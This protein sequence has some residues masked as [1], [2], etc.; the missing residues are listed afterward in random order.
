MI[1]N[2]FALQDRASTATLHVAIDPNRFVPDLQS[3]LGPMEDSNTTLNLD[4]TVSLEGVDMNAAT[5]AVMDY[6][7][8]VLGSGFVPPVPVSSA[9]S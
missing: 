7:W 5:L 3:L 9:V 2:L 4:P 1:L 6:G 8:T